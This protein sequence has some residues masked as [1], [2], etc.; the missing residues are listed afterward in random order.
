MYQ[1]ILVPVDGSA[2]SNQALDAAI[3]LAKA[4]KA[5]LRLIHVVDEMAYLSGYDQFGGYSGDLIRVMKESGAKVLTDALA[6]ARAAGV[7]AD[8][9][10]FDKFGERLGETVANAA[11][12]WEADLI[13]VGTH[14]RRGLGRVI[15]G[16]GAEQIIRNAPVHVLVVRGREE[17]TGGALA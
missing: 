13:V 4:F 8:D 5:R 9:I 15:L 6:V 14:G 10:L 16:S 7:E 11:K 3:G 1:R 2:T 17:A 12:L